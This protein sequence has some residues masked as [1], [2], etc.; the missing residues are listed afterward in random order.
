MRRA[1]ESRTTFYG[2]QG[3]CGE[4]LRSRKLGLHLCSPAKRFFFARHWCPADVRW[5]LTPVRGVGVVCKT[6]GIELCTE[7]ERGPARPGGSERGGR[8]AR[9][10]LPLRLAAGA[11]G[12]V[13]GSAGGGARFHTLLIGPALP[14]SWQKNVDPSL[15]GGLFF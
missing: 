13:A 7:T 5:W 1:R 8:G 2:V 6:R 14:E 11:A 9:A 10:G 3:G 12:A 4:G 15:D